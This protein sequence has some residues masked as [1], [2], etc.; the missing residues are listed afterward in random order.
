MRM[1]S[2]A[3]PPTSD[4]RSGGDADPGR[5]RML[6]LVSVAEL[7]GMSAWFTAAAIAP[8][9]RERWDLSAGQSG[10]LTAT[11]A[12]G[13][14]GGTG[15]AAI[16]NL[17]DV[18]PTRIYFASCALL[19]G[20]ANASLLLVPGYGPALASRFATGFFLAG[21]YPPAMKMAATWFRA[22][23]GL[24]IGIVVGA[25]VVGKATP[26]LAH[27]FAATRIDAVVLAASIGALVAG[28]LVIVGFREGP[29]PFERR[30]FS[31]SL[32][33]VAWRDRRTRLAIAGY[34]GHMWELY[35]MWAWTP[36]F[37]AAS[38]AA[39]TAAGA[40]PADP[41]LVDLLSFGSLA[42]GGLGCV[43]AG[44][45]ARRLGYARVVQISMAAS[46]L[47]SLAIAFC[48]GGDTWLL[49]AVAL[50]WGFFVVADSAQFSAMVTESAPPHAVGTALTLQVSTGFLLTMATIQA[51]PW[52]ASIV[53]W[54]WAFAVLA[55]GPAGGIA[56][57]RRLA[58]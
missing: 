4:P 26:Y 20:L 54:R 46:G 23:R 42:A 18:V 12:L 49:A 57:I 37:V 30:P 5:W 51:V 6:A 50:V 10:W 21:V 38:L 14:V 56:A 3:M 24:A 48:F 19:A 44:W 13:F 8:Q 52:L 34:L 36:A 22:S 35:A 45:A 25:L 2:A 17:A 58:R 39:R 32:A 53:G 15:T 55:L 31:W 43:W 1:Y 7:L 9:L 40:P 33:S 29:Y 41:R 28:V 27:A 47:C 16:L 11:V